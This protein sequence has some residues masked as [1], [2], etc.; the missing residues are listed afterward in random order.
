L[1]YLNSPVFTFN[2]VHKMIAWKALISIAPTADTPVYLQIANAMIINIRAGRLR[3]GLKLPGSRE[4]AHALQVHRKTVIAALDELQAQGW[5]EM[6]PRKGTFVVQH[7]PEI[8]PRK[9]IH[10]QTVAKYPAKTLFTIGEDHI[11][12][13]PVSDF[14]VQDRLI[15][16]DGFPDVRLAPAA[17]LARELRSIT[18]QS[19]FRKYFMYGSPSGPSYLRETLAAF[20]SDTRALPIASQNIMIT[21]GA[22]MGIYLTTKLLIKRGDHVV[23]GDPGYFGATLTFE[24]AGAVVNRVPVDSEGIDVDAV[25]LLCKR[26]KIRIVYVIPHHHHPT[27]VTLIPE[28]RLRLLELAAKYKFAIIEDDYDYDFHYTS[29]PVLP[30]ASLDH[31]GNVIYIGTLTKT[32]APSIRIGFVVAPENFIQLVARARRSIDYQGD[33]LMEMAIAQLYKNGTIGRHIKKVVKLYHERRDT[34]CK[35]LHDE[36]RDK[37]LFKIP[38]GGMS[39]WASFPNTDLKAMA[40]RAAT[41]KL[42]ISDG[43]LYASK[44]SGNSI[45]MGFASLNEHE[46]KRAIGILASCV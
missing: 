39:V 24:Q 22:Q 12:S 11:A 4:L 29:N 34:F 20:L 1:D 13:F 28:R 10:D 41:K 19:A 8:K 7:L 16:N 5:I 35:L 38:D 2:V 15:I 17:M 21:R 25:E 32:L 36:L 30:M 14:P 9:I 3:S 45:R 26:K 44:L 37:I 43:N 6:V 18:T 23:V 33:S 31:H 46:Q 42:V 40:A 27:T